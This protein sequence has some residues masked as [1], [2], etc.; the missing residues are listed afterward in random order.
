M[1]NIG[2]VTVGLLAI[3]AFV[4][5]GVTLPLGN[6]QGGNTDYS[7][8]AVLSAGVYDYFREQTSGYKSSEY[9]SEFQKIYSEYQKDVKN[10]NAQAK[11]GLFGGSV[12]LSAEQVRAMGEALYNREYKQD[13]IR[14]DSSYL[15]QTISNAPLEAWNECIESGTRGLKVLT[16]YGPDF[17]GPLTISLR[18]KV[19]NQ[20]QSI[21]VSRITVRGG[22]YKCTGTSLQSVLNSNKPV[23]LNVSSTSL[24]CERAFK[25]KPQQERGKLIW[26]SGASVVIETEAGTVIRY[27]GPIFA[28]SKTPTLE[29]EVAVLKKNVT[30]NFNALVPVG[31]IVAWHKQ[32]PGTKTLPKNWV[33]CNGQVISDKASPLNNQ[34]T[35]NLNGG[36]LF[37]RGAAQSGVPQ[38]QDWKSLTISSNGVGEPP[39]YVHDITLPKSGSNGQP[40]FSG[41]WGWAKDYPKATGLTFTYDTGAEIRPRNMSVVWIMRIK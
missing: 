39:A 25:P 34:A 40:F 26:A 3:C 8:N 2:R 20:N 17:E 12:S 24:S 13:Q 18:Y 4:A 29:K 7:C 16:E 21:K 1:R 14:N 33:E 9:Q 11:Y 41:A 5:L 27:L 36:G 38:E 15:R 19:D 10:G 6:A 22:L 37:L 32:M 23:L 35:P 30:E 28:S 31:S